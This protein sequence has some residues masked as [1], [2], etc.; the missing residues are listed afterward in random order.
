VVLDKADMVTAWLAAVRKHAKDLAESGNQIEGWKLVE[1]RGNRK[2][3]DGE[4]V[5]K[6]LQDMEGLDMEEFVTVISPAQVEKRL[7]RYGFELPENLTHSTP[8]EAG[9]NMVRESAKGIA[10]IPEAEF[11]TI[12]TTGEAK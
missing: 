7:R 12:P 8:S 1:K 2:W 6:L 5:L 10:V 3:I 4:V 11:E 9:L